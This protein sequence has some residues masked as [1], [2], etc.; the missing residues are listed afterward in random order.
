MVFYIKID[1]KYKN[2]EY[3]MLHE[4]WIKLD[5]SQAKIQSLTNN[6]KIFSKDN[7][8][9][10]TFSV[11]NIEDFNKLLKWSQEDEQKEFLIELHNNMLYENNT[12][13]TRRQI[14][15][16]KNDKYYEM[17]YNTNKYKLYKNITE[18]ISYIYDEKSSDKRDIMYIYKSKSK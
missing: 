11:K 10:Q 2:N 1:V 8:I 14:T 4:E 3:S 12:L 7:N 16:V 9:L 13:S 6:H 5:T 17:I 18:E 15:S